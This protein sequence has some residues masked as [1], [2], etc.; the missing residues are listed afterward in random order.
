MSKLLEGKVALVTGGGR[1]VGRGIALALAAAGASVVVNDLGAGLDGSPESERPA[2][3]VIAAIE[4]LG[5][6][7]VADGG[8]VADW[9][10]A[11]AMVRAAVDAFGRIDIVVNN[12]GILRDAIFHRMTEQE[13]DDVVSVHLKGCFNV[14][15]AAAPYFK[16]QG[17]GSFVHMTSTSGLI[18]N[19]G[20]ANYSAAKLGIA[21]LSKSIAIDMQKFG[22]RSN[23]VAPF[24]WTRMVDSIP[25]E[26]AEQKRRVDSLKKLLPERVAPFVVA[27]CADAASD[28]TGQVFGVRNNEIHLFSQPRPIRNAHRGEGWTPESVID[29]ALPMLRPAFYALDRS[30]DVFT[31]DPV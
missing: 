18:G 7:A 9:A 27:L 14:S 13:F 8:S 4:A 30:G 5:G 21:A 29:T 6:R 25:N 10:A 3:D 31:W 2:L 24:A 19:V 15:R 26:T 28:V 11:Q 1:G 22:V 12:A 20:Q 16:E 23:A 17:G